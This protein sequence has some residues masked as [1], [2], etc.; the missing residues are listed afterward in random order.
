MIVGKIFIIIIF[1]KYF[2]WKVIFWFLIII[3]YISI[4]FEKIKKVVKIKN[5]LLIKL[6]RIFV[7]IYLKKSKVNSELDFLKF[8]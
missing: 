5:S 6:V 3:Y 1:L 2:Y 8:K 7:L 4:F